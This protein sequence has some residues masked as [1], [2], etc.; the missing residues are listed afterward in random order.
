MAPLLR[1]DR[2][3][4]ERLHPLLTVST[5]ALLS[6]EDELA[7][8]RRANPTGLTL[9]LRTA[10]GRKSILSGAFSNQSV[11]NPLTLRGNRSNNWLGESGLSQGARL[12]QNVRLEP[13][14]EQVA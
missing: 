10:S 13:H 7:T 8:A 3:R 12:V 1:A 5:A 9:R 14:P 6:G 11:E 4:V 2:Q